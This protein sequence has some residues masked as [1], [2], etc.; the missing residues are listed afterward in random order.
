[1]FFGAGNVLFPFMLGEFA[2][3]SVT[4]AILGF[5]FAGV[6]VPFL[7]LFAIAIY[8]GDWRT[9]FGRIGDK[10]GLWLFTFLI[11]ILGPLGSI[12]RLITVS[13]G[14]MEP[15]LMGMSLPLFS[16][17]ACVASFLFAIRKSQVI[18]ILGA[19]LTPILLIS[20]GIIVI[21]G[22][23]SPPPLPADG[24]SALRSFGEGM[25]W[26]YSLM[27]ML[28]A[29]LFGALVLND[30]KSDGQGRAFARMG[31]V[32]AGSSVDDVI[33]RA[34]ELHPDYPPQESNGP[35]A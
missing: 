3:A 4:S 10:P 29:F 19:I 23:W 31:F 14:T 20:L 24:P 30:F 12:P 7:G 2:G 13:Y 25:H 35:G 15:Y 27:D 33:Y 34:R 18:K 8:G 1:M 32:S 28:A 21:G 16:L 9:F 11:L 6:A 26:G 17:L 22:L 5:L